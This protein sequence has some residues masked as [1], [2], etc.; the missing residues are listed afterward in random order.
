MTINGFPAAAI[1]TGVDVG[2]KKAATLLCYA[3]FGLEMAEECWYGVSRWQGAWMVWSG[4]FTPILRQ[5]SKKR[6]SFFLAHTF[7]NTRFLMA[8]PYYDDQVVI[9]YL[10]KGCGNN[11]PIR[12]FLGLDNLNSVFSIFLF[13][14]WINRSLFLSL[15]KY[16]SC[17]IWVYVFFLRD[18]F[19][20]W[21]CHDSM[22]P[23]KTL[24][25][26]LLSFWGIGVN[27][28]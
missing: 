2:L 20:S 25:S 23:Y 17:G 24:R 21:M 3:Q 6:P 15:D 10:S 13:C 9:K 11:Q 28:R 14:S 1:S 27:S 26:F 22:G 8:Q 7:G 16:L 18:D 19:W 12:V 4:G 5:L